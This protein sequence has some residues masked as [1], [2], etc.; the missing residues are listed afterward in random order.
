MINC[1]DLQYGDIVVVRCNDNTIEVG[2]VRGVSQLNGSP[3]VDYTIG[4]ER[5]RWAYVDKVIQHTKV[6]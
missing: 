5:N 4:R 3:V 6:S 1:N 2:T